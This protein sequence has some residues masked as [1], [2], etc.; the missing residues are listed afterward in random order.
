M[1]VAYRTVLHRFYRSSKRHALGRASTLRM[2]DG[3]PVDVL[4]EDVSASGCRLSG[5]PDLRPHEAILIGLAGL[6]SRP[7]RIVWMQEGEAGCRFDMPLSDGE[8]ARAQQAGVVVTAM[9]DRVQDAMPDRALV[10]T[11]AR[12]SGEPRVRLAIICL[13]AVMSWALVAAILL[14]GWRLAA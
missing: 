7:A 3:A 8:L 14:I 12:A 13:A 11:D 5:T 2:Q 4:V 9:F 10:S 6:G 1:T